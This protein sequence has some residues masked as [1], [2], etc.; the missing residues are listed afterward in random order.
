MSAFQLVAFADG[1]FGAY[2]LESPLETL[3]I[4]RTP[5]EAMGRARELLAAQVRERAAPPVVERFLEHKGKRGLE[6]C[7]PVLA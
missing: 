5:L 1:D 7:F 4:G 2:A 3:G 6:A